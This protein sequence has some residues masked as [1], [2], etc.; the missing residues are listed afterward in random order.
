MGRQLDARDERRPIRSQQITDDMKKIWLISIVYFLIQG[1][2]AQNPGSYNANLKNLNDATDSTEFNFR[3]EAAPLI[4]LTCNQKDN[5]AQLGGA[6]IISVLEAGG[7]PVI[8]PAVTNAQTL[9]DILSR[10]DGIIL[11]GG[12][13]VNPL[14]YNEQPRQQLGTVDPVRDMNEMK[15]IRIATER[16]IPI[17]GICRGL[18]ILNVALGGTLYQ[19]IP[20]QKPNAIK[21]VQSLPGPQPSHSVTITKGSVLESILG[22]NSL[23][24]NSFHHQGVKSIAPGMRIVAYASD[25][26]PEAFEGW[27]NRPVMGVQWHPEQMTIGGDSTMLKLF[28][29]LV[30]KARIYHEAREL[31]KR[32]LS[33][34]THTD[35]PLWFRKPGFNISKR[36][37]NM[38]N[39]PKMEEG[40][41]DGQFLA[42]FIGQKARDEAS[43]LK[44]VADVTGLIQGIHKQVEQNSDICGIAITE[45]DFKKLKSEGKRAFFIG[46][47]NGYG[48]GK[49]L[50]NI[51][52][53]KAMGV[54]YITLCHSYDND[55]C[56]SSTHTKNEWKGLSPFGE[57]V[58]KEMNR[59]GILVDLSHANEST[60]WDVMKLST[61]P[62]ICS[63]SSARAV[64]DH[65]RNLTDEQLKALAKNGGVVQV[66]FLDRY[67][68]KDYKNASVMDVID[69]ID[70]IVKVAGIDHV[71]IGTDFDGG[72]GVIGCEG[73]NDLIQ[74]TCKLLE[75][76]YSEQDIA[77]I[78]GGNFLRVLSQV[79]A[80]AAK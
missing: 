80:A 17:L 12:E 79:Q 8:I 21:H 25:S 9:R 51:A 14:W 1:A 7:A 45:A 5:A 48:I 41:L 66:C 37:K 56:D 73:D 78:W 69:H 67:I 47:E 15:I 50:A 77:K 71:G 29:F 55:I 20:S 74:I 64:C 13:D 27:P 75:R 61:V 76:G 38:V 42:A 59:L 16:N 65:D 33:I 26:I 44:A 53:F 40:C 34:D 46:I 58:V 28:R 35:A 19:D 72:G 23:T 63:H 68:N 60:F 6:Y 32:I 24:V 18:Q 3:H 52:K 30:G 10:L 22:K 11:T 70:H 36:E 57:Q 49:D 39:V 43:L 4:G 54:N 2:C 62:V 31:H